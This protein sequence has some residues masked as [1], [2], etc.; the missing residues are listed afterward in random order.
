MKKIFFIICFLLPLGFLSVFANAA[1]PGG[2]YF[3]DKWEISG[4]VG[5]SKM[6]FELRG[7]TSRL[8]KEF[9]HK[10][11]Y[12]F[13]LSLSRTVRLHWKPSFSMYFYHF[14]GDNDNPVFSAI[15]KNADFDDFVRA[16]VEYKTDMWAVMLGTRYY[17]WEFTRPEYKKLS[18]NPYLELQVG[19]N[20]LSTVLGYKDPPAGR[21]G[22]IFE[23]GKGDPMR[24]ATVIG[25]YSFGGGTEINLHHSWKL[26]V[27]WNF[28]FIDYN[29][30]DAVHNYYSSGEEIYTMDVVSR[31]MVGIIIPVRKKK[32]GYKI[33]APR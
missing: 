23:K 15:G 10:P 33:W 13:G 9:K 16:P 1:S 6:L 8:P 25:Q 4:Q 5:T 18:L 14:S 27:G 17:L 26:S 29:C 21:A 32:P 2:S 31:L 28:D 20:F 7:L 3:P 24:P 30:V 11:G 22:L 19:L 12:T